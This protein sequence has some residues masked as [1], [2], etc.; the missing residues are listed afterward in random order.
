MSQRSNPFLSPPPVAGCGEGRG[1]LRRI[2]ARI[3]DAPF[4]TFPLRQGEGIRVRRSIIF[5]GQQWA[6]AGM[7][8]ISDRLSTPDYATPSNSE[9]L[10]NIESN[11]EY[12]SADRRR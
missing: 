3:P 8:V 1:D 2:E 5:P 7:T 9:R 4:L 6:F 10:P 12:R 11:R